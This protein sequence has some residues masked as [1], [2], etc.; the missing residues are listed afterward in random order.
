[1]TKNDLFV[2]SPLLFFVLLLRASLDPVFDMFKFGGIGFGALFNL[3]IVILF[4]YVCLRNKLSFPFSF[5]SVWGGFILIGFTS[6]LESPDKVTSLR[7]FFSVLTYFSLFCLAYFFTVNKNSFISFLRIIIYSSFIPFV[8]SMYQIFFSEINISNPDF[9]LFGSFSH[10]NIYAFYLVLVNSVS[11]YLLKT[12]IF[13]VST[14]FTYLLYFVIVFSLF[15]LLLTKTRSAWLSIII[16][17]F[18]YGLFSNKRYLLYLF[19]AVI[20]SL[21][22][23]QVQER[24]FEVFS[25][26]DFHSLAEGESLNS[27]AWRKIVW[28]SSWS[29]IIEKPLLGYGY[30]TFSYYFLNF[31]A[32]EEN[33]GF[34]AHN[35]FVQ[36]SFD[37]GFLGLIAYLV[38]IFSVAKRVLLFSRVDNGCYSI[39]LGLI[40]S[41]FAIGYSDNILFYLSYNWYF[42]FLMGCIYFF[43]KCNLKN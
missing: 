39:F 30:D 13:E 26:N 21:M 18:I 6:I 16:V 8:F 15:F 1:M 29:M 43:P 20:F 32:L 7:S 28:L 23:P 37:M 10:P 19:I 14:R 17:F 4:L 41:Y 25:S 9:R 12:K 36:I 31:F 40:I 35:V 33:K 24:V 11:F 2:F 3:L 38:I 27:Y 42:W 5:F 22:F 34:D